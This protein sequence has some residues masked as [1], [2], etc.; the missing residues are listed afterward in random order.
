MKNKIIDLTKESILSITHPRFFSNERAYQ[1]RL[2]CNLLNT[3]V[4]QGLLDDEELIEIEYQKS[5]RHS[6]SQRPDIIY[7]I[8][9]EMKKTAVDKNNYAVWAIKKS[10]TLDKAKSDF[11]KLDEMFSILNYSLGIFINIGSEKT[12]LDSYDGKFKERLV[13]YAILINNNRIYL[14]RN[15]FGEKGIIIEFFESRKV[16][17]NESLE[18]TGDAGSFS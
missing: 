1:G 14:K 11:E 8:P 18:R 3:F 7:H 12:Y 16:N 17:T 2:Y 9:A 10:A 4:R 5:T 6:M 15:T 13:S